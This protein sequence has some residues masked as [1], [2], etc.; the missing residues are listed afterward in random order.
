MYQYL[1]HENAI[2]KACQILNELSVHQYRQQAYIYIVYIKGIISLLQILIRLSFCTE[3][4]NKRER[5]GN[6]VLQKQSVIFS[7]NRTLLQCDLW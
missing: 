6:L 3:R 2:C 1:S 5:I 7:V 4:T